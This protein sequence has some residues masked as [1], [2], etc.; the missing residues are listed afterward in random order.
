VVSWTL[1]SDGSGGPAPY[2]PGGNP[3]V[4]LPGHKIYSVSNGNIA[5]SILLN[6]TLDLQATVNHSHGHVSGNGTL[7]IGST[8]AGYLF[9]R[10][11]NMMLL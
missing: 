3:V 10:A 9:S 5:Y 8:P 6:G 1:I 11:E 7:I 4:I 2:I